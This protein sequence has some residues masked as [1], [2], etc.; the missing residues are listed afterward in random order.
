MKT[1]RFS[2]LK[3]QSA[4]FSVEPTRFREHFLLKFV[5][6][7]RAGSDVL[8]KVARP[9][10]GGT[11]DLLLRGAYMKRL[12]NKEEREIKQ[13]KIRG[14]P[15]RI[16]EYRKRISDEAYLDH[17]IKKIATDLSHYLTK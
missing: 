6:E 8:S 10:H 11:G 3:T 14:D 12:M 2:G 5:N 4:E 15:K 13:G 1:A 16:E 17:A 7:K 9:V